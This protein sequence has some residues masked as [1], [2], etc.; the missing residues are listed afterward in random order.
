VK[1]LLIALVLAALAIPA[2]A[3]LS[4]KYKDWGSSPQAYFMTKAERAQWDAVKTDEEAQTFVDKFLASRGPNF[5]AE[6]ADRAARADQYFTIGKAAGSKS[7]RGKVII[8]LGPPA[9]LEVVNEN[10][11]HVHRDNPDAAGAM[12]GGSSGAG[13][14]GGKGGGGGM[15]GDST[16]FGSQMLSV[17]SVRKYHFTYADP[18]L[19][20]VVPADPNTG[21]DLPMKRADKLAL[22][23]AFELAAAASV[24]K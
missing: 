8:L 5:A 3:A 7:M 15:G 20:V 14:G 13:S 1:R 18:K 9:G 23:D 4:A 19:D 2:S 24:R 11:T 22:E 6:V 17:N 12:T 16:S 10:D 21:K